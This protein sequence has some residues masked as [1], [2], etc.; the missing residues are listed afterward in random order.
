M[1][2][3]PP[4]DETSMPPWPNAV[5][6]RRL[7]VIAAS[8]GGL[9]PVIDVLSGLSS[10]FPAAVVVVQHRSDDYADVLPDILRR[11][12]TLRVRAAQEGDYLEAGTD[13]VCPPGVH[14]TVERSL[15][16]AAAPGW[17]TSVP[18]PT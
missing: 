2:P 11:H 8:A 17:S 18:T 9:R 6:S 7:V 12:T 5:S 15:R 13:Y 1:T 10:D 16:L 4:T 3:E 14:L